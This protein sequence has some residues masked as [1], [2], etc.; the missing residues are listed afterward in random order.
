MTVKLGAGRELRKL[1]GHLIPG[2]QVRYLAGGVVNR[3]QGLVALT[4]RRLLMLFHGH[5]RQSL[6]DIPLDRITAVREKAGMLMGTLTVVASG[7]EMVISQVPKQDMKNLAQA[8]RTRMASGSLPQL[9][10]VELRD[11]EPVT[12]EPDTAPLVSEGAQPDLVEQLAQLAALKDSGALTQKSSKAPNDDY[13]A[14][15][16]PARESGKQPVS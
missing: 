6:E 1:K 13:L 2:E 3:R 12:S 9:P 11:S 14:T 7:T 10:A 15:A 4:D 5:L 8:L 16:N